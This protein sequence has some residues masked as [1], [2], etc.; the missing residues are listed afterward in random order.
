MG[1]FRVF[2]IKT[3]A[4]HKL[5]EVKSNMGF[6]FLV[7]FLV[8]WGGGWTLTAKLQSA[9][10]WD[11]SSWSRGDNPLWGCCHFPSD[12]MMWVA[13]VWACPLYWR[14]RNG[15]SAQKRQNC[16][17]AV[18]LSRYDCSYIY[19]RLFHTV[20][21]A[22]LSWVSCFSAC[23]AVIVK[24]FEQSRLQCFA[25]TVSEAFMSLCID[26]RFKLYSYTR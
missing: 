16:R 21:C 7:C 19:W 17:K 4:K 1:L 14:V 8:G 3:A 9:E 13:T 23:I 15:S 20:L 18:H 26:L 11:N 22:Y 24:I 2:F 25:Y 6:V 10:T 12:C 5:D